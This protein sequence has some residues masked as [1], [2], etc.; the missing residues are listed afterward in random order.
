MWGPVWCGSGWW[1]TGNG[2]LNGAPEVP[3]RSWQLNAGC[4]PLA[5]RARLD[6]DLGR[7]DCFATCFAGRAALAQF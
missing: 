1:G 5:L 3:R 6:L 2:E 7:L 4:G